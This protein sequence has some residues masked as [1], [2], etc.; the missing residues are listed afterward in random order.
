MARGLRFNSRFAMANTARRFRWTTIVRLVFAGWYP[1][2]DR[3]PQLR[4]PMSFELFPAA[5]RVLA[6]FGN[7]KF[8]NSSERTWLD[9]SSGD[10]VADRIWE[11]EGKLGR[12]LY[13]IGYYEHQDRD[14]YLI[15]ESGIVY[16]LWGDTLEPLASSIERA[17][18]HVFLRGMRRN[19][20]IDEDLKAIGMQGKQWH[21][22]ERQ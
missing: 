3:C 8:G 6:E 5:K 12:R 19:R 15:D 9:P 4:L 1:K 18:E 22:D 20:D 14:Y 7:L 13:P 2:R 17:L 10:E 11:C 16:E 21:L